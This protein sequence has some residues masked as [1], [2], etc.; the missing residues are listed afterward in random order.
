MSARWEKVW[1]RLNAPITIW[2]LTVVAVGI[3][4]AIYQD[5]ERCRTE[6][7]H[8]V[9]TYQRLST[10]IGTR[11]GDLAH[12][13]HEAD[14]VA[15]LRKSA[16]VQ[17]W[18]QQYTFLEFKGRTLTDLE[19]EYWRVAVKLRHVPKLLWKLQN[20]NM[21]NAV[22]LWSS[23]SEAGSGKDRAR[24]VKF[25]RP[26]FSRLKEADLPTLKARAKGIDFTPLDLV[27]ERWGYRVVSACHAVTAMSRILIGYPN[28]VAEI[29]EEPA[30]TAKKVSR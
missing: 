21:E 3:V 23:V 1:R 14:T 2:L 26:D 11:Y 4:G 13:I 7:D 6:A 16:V 18:D 12:A 9:A 22:A 25:R 20:E 27:S 5:V 8:V 24:N 19:D 29:R 17:N 28:Y 10:E 30:W 15:E